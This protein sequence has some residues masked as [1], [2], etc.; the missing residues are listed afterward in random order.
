MKGIIWISSNTLITVYNAESWHYGVSSKHHRRAAQWPACFQ[1][2]IKHKTFW[3][4]L[5]HCEALWNIVKHFETQWNTLKHNGTLWNAM[6]HYETQWN[7]MKHLGTLW[8]MR[9]ILGHETLWNIL[10]WNIN[11]SCYKTFHD[12]KCSKMFYGVSQCSLMFCNISVFQD[13]S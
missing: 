3:N 12:S 6:K 10:V 1:T 13:V 7:I 2:L 5:K 9:E 8:N 4:I 11:V